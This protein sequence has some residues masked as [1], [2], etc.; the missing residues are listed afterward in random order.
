LGACGQVPESGVDGRVGLSLG[1]GV[2]TTRATVTALTA[3]TALAPLALLAVTAPTREVA[4][5]SGGHD[6]VGLSLGHITS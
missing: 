2:A 6:L 1:G 5:L 3:L 4:S